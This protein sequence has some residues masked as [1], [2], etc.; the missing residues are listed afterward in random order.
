MSIGL[1]ASMVGIFVVRGR[2]GE[3][4]ALKAI[5]RGIYTAQAIAI[6]GAAVVAFVYVGN[7]AGSRLSNPAPASSAPS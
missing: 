1:L 3:T 5:N 4:D 2:P 6:L 7:P